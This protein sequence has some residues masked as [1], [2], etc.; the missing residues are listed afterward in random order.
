MK[1][2]HEHRNPGQCIRT[3]QANILAK[4]GSGRKFTQNR[5]GPF[6]GPQD[7]V[8]SLE[9]IECLCLFMNDGGNR[10][11]GVIILKS[12]GEWMPSQCYARFFFHSPARRLQKALVSETMLTGNSCRD[13]G[14]GRNVGWGR[15]VWFARKK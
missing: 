5:Y 9:L 7:F 4:I 6:E 15:G 13:S 3:Y 11:D 1:V 8:L 14:T 12:V 2:G 10:L